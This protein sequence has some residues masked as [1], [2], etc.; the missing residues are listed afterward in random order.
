ADTSINDGIDV[1]VDEATVV[2]TA[3]SGPGTASAGISV[4]A[5]GIVSRSFIQ[6][7]ASG[8]DGITLSG[9]AAKA[10][11]NTIAGVDG[12]GRGISSTG[13][14]SVIQGNTITGDAATGAGIVSSG[15]TADIHGNRI[16]SSP[17]DTLQKGI[18]VS[19]QRDTTVSNNKVDRVHDS[20][21]V[22]SAWAARG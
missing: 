21:Y 12:E 19:G 11:F 14:D 6:Y 4:A 17:D 3:S 22:H 15:N 5:R 16:I 13:D 1:R 9:A 2:P 8:A 7:L 18:V 20:A 10:M